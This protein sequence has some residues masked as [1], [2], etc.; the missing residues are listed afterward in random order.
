ML[1]VYCVSALDKSI[2]WET[3]V[4]N[5]AQ[6]DQGSVLVLVSPPGKSLGLDTT[7]VTM[8]KMIMMMKTMMRNTM[9]MTTMT[10][11]MIYDDYAYCAAQLLNM[12]PECRAT[13]SDAL[14]ATRYV[15]R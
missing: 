11:T 1:S 15:L 7:L 10:M 9:M 8:N 4:V 3:S 2:G 14:K 5:T 6:F 13:A 12:L